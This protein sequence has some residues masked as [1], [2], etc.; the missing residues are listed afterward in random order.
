MDLDIWLVGCLVG[1]LSHYCAYKYGKYQGWLDTFRKD[2][3]YRYGKAGM[4]LREG[5]TFL[6][7]VDAKKGPYFFV[8][9][10]GRDVESE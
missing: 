3:R 1:S 4:A 6:G 8:A 9:N 10:A 5:E 2:A 7:V